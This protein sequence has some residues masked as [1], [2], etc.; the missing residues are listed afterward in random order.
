MDIALFTNDAVKTRTWKCKFILM[1]HHLTLCHLFSHGPLIISFSS[2]F[3][4]WLSSQIDTALSARLNAWRKTQPL[5]EGL[6]REFLT[7]ESFKEALPCQWWVVMSLLTCC[8][9]DF[10][11]LC[12]YQK[13]KKETRTSAFTQKL[14]QQGTY[15]FILQ[16]PSLQDLQ[17]GF[18][19][20]KNKEQIKI[21]L[22]LDFI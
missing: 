13:M 10:M 17:P 14:S 19:F 11:S 22:R 2:P 3:L 8:H 5:W 9:K 21:K 7:F 15:T 18:C 20:C 6:R 16:D 12:R 1:K 4:S